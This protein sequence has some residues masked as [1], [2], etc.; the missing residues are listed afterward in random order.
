M[1]KIADV[2]PCWNRTNRVAARQEGAKPVAEARE[3]LLGRTGKLEDLKRAAQ[4]YAELCLA[5]VWI[6]A[7]RGRTHIVEPAPRE[8]SSPGADS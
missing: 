2:R 8:G 3:A 5:E 6:A 7:E 4:A 1:A